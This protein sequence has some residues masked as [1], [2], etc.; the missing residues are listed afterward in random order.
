MKRKNSTKKGLRNGSPS[1]IYKV[2]NLWLALSVDNETFGY[3]AFFCV[4][5]GYIYA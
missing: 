5:P 3:N 4:N 2:V 1:L